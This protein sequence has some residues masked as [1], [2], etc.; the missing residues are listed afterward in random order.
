M[1]GGGGG[2]GGGVACPPNV[3]VNKLLI[4]FC[5]LSFSQLTNL[6][7]R[8]LKTIMLTRFISL[9]WPQ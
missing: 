5:D 6:G 7:R 8:L 4:N 3:W 9:N 1:G 2:G